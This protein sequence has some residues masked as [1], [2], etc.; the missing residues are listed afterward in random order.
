MK[1]ITVYAADDG[2]RWDK[3]RDA[4]TRDILIR[5]VE[6][7]KAHIGL[8]PWPEAESCTNGT[9]FLAQPVGVRDKIFSF[10]KDNGWHRDMASCPIGRLC[11]IA[12]CIDSKGRQWDQQYHAAN[13]VDAINSGATEI[14]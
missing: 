10:C 9:R 13:C 7:F 2:S 1:T 11:R 6:A 8:R 3:D 4:A 12:Y 5:E 14:V